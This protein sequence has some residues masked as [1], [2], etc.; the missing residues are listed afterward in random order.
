MGGCVFASLVYDINR[1][2]E[3]KLNAHLLPFVLLFILRLHFIFNFNLPGACPH[4]VIVRGRG[5]GRG[6]YVFEED[7]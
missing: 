7:E 2:N 6:G 5:Q 1:H 4:V 3:A